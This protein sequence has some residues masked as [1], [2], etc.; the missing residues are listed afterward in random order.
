MLSMR[1]S[2]VT[3]VSTCFRGCFGALGYVGAG[4]RLT[5]TGA[6]SSVME[7]SESLIVVNA[8]SCPAGQ[9]GLRD[10]YMEAAPPDVSASWRNP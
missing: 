6:A 10:P 2:Q 3:S 4:G 9:T 1:R 7:I 5:E 8:I